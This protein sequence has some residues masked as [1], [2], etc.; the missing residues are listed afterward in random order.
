MAYMAGKARLPEKLVLD[1]A[2]ETVARF[3][4][5]WRTEKDNL[6]LTK[7]M[8]GTIEKHIQTVPIADG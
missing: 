4:D 7:D 2:R 1:T 5:V 3:H 8:I 6:P